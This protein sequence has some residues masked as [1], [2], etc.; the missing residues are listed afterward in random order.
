MAYRALGSL[1]VVSILTFLLLVVLKLQFIIDV[2]WMIVF[3][4]FWAF[5]ILLVILAYDIKRQFNNKNH[6]EFAR[7]FWISII[8]FLICFMAM[9][10]LIEFALTHTWE[11]NHDDSRKVGIYD[12]DRIG[13]FCGC[14]SS[15]LEYLFDH[16]DCYWKSNVMNIT[17]DSCGDR[18]IGFEEIY[19]DYLGTLECTIDSVDS[20]TGKQVRI[21][22][23]EE[24]SRVIPSWAI[25]TPILL[26]ITV[27]FFLIM[28]NKRQL[29]FMIENNEPSHDD[30]LSVQ[31]NNVVGDEY[32]EATDD[33]KK[34]FEDRDNDS[35]EEDARVELDDGADYTLDKNDTDE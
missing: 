17:G 21:E 19:N 12:T 24:C 18:M 11:C 14:F 3:I 26:M 28:K 2:S 8:F 15:E 31:M 7:T 22:I 5:D 33:E 32:L 13:D 16:A 29:F 20:L 6:H 35:E 4:P 9:Q 23:G 30:A 34:K 10:I 1:I 27:V 25:I